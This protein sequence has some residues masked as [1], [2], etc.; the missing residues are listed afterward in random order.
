MR[1]LSLNAWGGRLHDRLIDYLREVDPDVLC[2][3]EITRAP[4]GA[5]EWLSYRDGGLELPQ[6]ANLF[7]EICHALPAH[8]PFFCPAAR[9]DLYDGERPVPSEL[10][11]ATF[12]RAAFPIIGQAQDFVHGEFAAEGWGERPRPRNAHV[13]RLYDGRG[14]STMTVG[15]MHGLRDPSGMSDTPARHAQAEALL[16]L[17]RRVRRG[18]ETLVV[19][20]DFNLL[21]ESATFGSRPSRWWRFWDARLR[22]SF[23][24]PALQC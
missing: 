10:G 24:R 23:R 8:Q 17:I 12:V 7:R 13:V 1:I 5:P 15:H 14:S 4:D 6:R 22:S 3:Q 11:L 16:E 2:L 19:C 21:P 20:G 18:G 9:G